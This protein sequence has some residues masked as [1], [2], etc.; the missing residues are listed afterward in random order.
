MNSSF[1]ERTLFKSLRTFVVPLFDQV[2]IAVQEQIIVIQVAAEQVI[3]IITESIS[4]IIIALN[5]RWNNR[6][7]KV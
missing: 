4:R 6:P 7:R 2:S 5:K 3:A 1:F